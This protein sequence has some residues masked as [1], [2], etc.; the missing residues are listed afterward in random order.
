MAVS[1]MAALLPLGQL[2]GLILVIALGTAPSLVARLIGLV[3]IVAIAVLQALGPLPNLVMLIF[4]LVGL[5]LAIAADVWAATLRTWAWRAT[6]QGVWGSIIG[7]FIGMFLDLGMM[8]FIVGT[9]V[10]AVIGEIVSRR[11][12]G[13]QVVRAAAGTLMNLWGAAGIKLL[14]A[15]ALLGH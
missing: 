9:F 8:G 2:L 7:G 3:I 6:S 13:I 14:V 5:A 15:L 4:A 10:G 11:W 12:G 1:V